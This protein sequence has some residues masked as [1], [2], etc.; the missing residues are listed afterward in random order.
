MTFLALLCSLGISWGALVDSLAGP[1]AAT[2]ADSVSGATAASVTIDSGAD[3]ALVFLDSVPRGLTPLTIDSLPPGSHVLRL[4]HADAASW[5]T[6]TIV[7]TLHLAAGERRT[8][9]YSFERRILIITDPSGAV[10]F[11]GD[12]SLGTTPLAFSVPAEGIPGGISAA[13]QGYETAVLPLPP[14]Q[15][16]ITRAVL[17]KLW[18]SEPPEGALMKE[19]N[20]DRSSLRLYVAGGITLVSG[21]AAA[22]FKIKADNR[23]AEF[24]L[25]GNPALRNETRRLDTAAA[26]SLVATQIGFGFLTYFLLAD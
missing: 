22:Y 23:N 6:G 8:L 5:L 7:D 19:S 18:Q 21:M 16:G 20:G 9:R 2:A 4:V 12:S 26:L 1:A 15:G 24:Q 25:S 11:A 10:V 17:K 13:K 14:G 3:S